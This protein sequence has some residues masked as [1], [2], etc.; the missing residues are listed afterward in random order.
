MPN[1]WSSSKG[2]KNAI[3]K[4]EKKYIENKCEPLP[5]G[6]PTQSLRQVAERGTDRGVI[7]CLLHPLTACTWMLSAGAPWPDTHSPP[8]S[9]GAEFPLT[10]TASGD[11]RYPQLAAPRTPANCPRRRLARKGLRP[12]APACRPPGPTR[13]GARGKGGTG[14]KVPRFKARAISDCRASLGVRWQP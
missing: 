10:L 9:Y 11:S 14:G 4:P 8:C 6:L 12:R 7:G 2:S 3:K 13:L 5:C 1:S